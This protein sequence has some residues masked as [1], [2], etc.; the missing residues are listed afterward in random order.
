MLGL[1]SITLLA[2]SA[3][4]VLAVDPHVAFDFGRIAECTEISGEEVQSLYPDEKLVELK[5]QVSVHL[6]AGN[7]RDVEEVRIEIGDCDDRMRV[8]SYSPSTRLESHLSEDIQWTKTTE[9]TSSLGASLG[10]ELPTPVGG[11]VAHVTPTLSSGKQ[12][13]ETITEKQ[14]RVAPKIAVIAS[15][16]IAQERGVFFKLRNAPSTSLEGSHEL[17]VRFV[18]PKNWRG[19]S[20]RVCCQATGKEKVLW[21]KQQTTWS[22]TCAPVALY[23]SGD[24]EARQA[25]IR[26][27]DSKERS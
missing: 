25:A 3:P 10:G 11:L 14:T 26:F 9:D 16:T 6:L 4:P 23:L 18:V 13:R 7:I 22:H 2:I 5:L 15:G 27:A 21:I 1:L 8:A 24:T 12:G 20:I 17:S 19:S